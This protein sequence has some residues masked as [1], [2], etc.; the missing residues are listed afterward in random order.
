M[1][2][3]IQFSIIYTP[4]SVV[5]IDLQLNVSYKT[6]LI[7]CASLGLLHIHEMNNGRKSLFRLPHT[8]EAT[9]LYH[10]DYVM[11][12]LYDCAK[13]SL[14]LC[15]PLQGIIQRGG[16]GVSPNNFKGCIQWQQMQVHQKQPQDLEKL[17]KI[18]P[19]ALCRHAHCYI[20]LKMKPA[21]L[22]LIHSFTV[23]LRCVRLSQQGQFYFYTM[24]SFFGNL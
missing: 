21:L 17:A 14:S 5:L 2:I 1:V 11:Y 24:A 22:S 18:Y 7:F 13:S 3:W 20:S 8:S 16:P 4:V 23:S 10:I 19:G 12:S 9:R 15:Y 6:I